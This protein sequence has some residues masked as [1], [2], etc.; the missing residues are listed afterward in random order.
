L[1]ERAGAW[2]LQVDPVTQVLS[3]KVG[4]VFGNGTARL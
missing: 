1:V 3:N 2:F 4:L